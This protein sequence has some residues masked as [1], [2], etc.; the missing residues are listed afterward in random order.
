MCIVFFVYK[1]RIVKKY[2]YDS[3]S[4]EEKARFKLQNGIVMTDRFKQAAA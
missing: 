4:Y 3:T 1:I 2:Y